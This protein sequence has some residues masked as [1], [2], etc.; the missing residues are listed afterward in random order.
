MSDTTIDN[1]QFFID[2]GKFVDIILDDPKLFQ[3]TYH[4]LEL[5]QGV[6]YDN[7]AIAKAINAEAIKKI[8]EEL[9][10]SKP[11]ADASDGANIGACIC[12]IFC[13]LLLFVPGG[14]LV[15]ISGIAAT[16]GGVGATVASL[17]LAATEFGMDVDVQIKLKE[18]EKNET[19]MLA[20]NLAYECASSIGVLADIDELYQKQSPLLSSNQCFMAVA[21]E[22]DEAKGQVEAFKKG[23]KV[24]QNISRDKASIDFFKRFTKDDLLKMTTKDGLL[25]D[26]VAIAE[27]VKAS[28]KVPL[29]IQKVVSGVGK[30][31]GVMKG[32]YNRRPGRIVDIA[33]DAEFGVEDM[34]LINVTQNMSRTGVT[35]A[36][37]VIGGASKFSKCFAALGGILDVVGGI[38]S[39]IAIC[40]RKENA[41]EMQKKLQEA[42]DN[43]SDSMDE[44]KIFQETFFPR[45]GDALRVIIDSYRL[46]TL[47][48]NQKAFNSADSSLSMG[49]VIDNRSKYTFDVYAVVPFYGS[50]YYVPGGSLVGSK[51]MSEEISDRFKKEG[52]GDVLAFMKKKD[53]H[54][55]RCIGGASHW[56]GVTG[57][58]FSGMFVL[59]ARGE[60][61]I[62]IPIWFYYSTSKPWEVMGAYADIP[63]FYGSDGNKIYQHMKN[64]AHA[65]NKVHSWGGNGVH[66]IENALLRIS[67]SDPSKR[68]DVTIED[69][70]K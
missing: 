10:K 28:L 9:A 16:V 27:L 23:L 8:K 37:K 64:E 39:I 2:F 41:E 70:I 45:P 43:F 7:V 13:S 40:K 60:R 67:F 18:I 56:W 61:E 26:P 25:A 57:F 50:W 31:F 35:E 15:A 46:D 24:Y 49:L 53:Y 68:I 44:I 19:T 62:Q 52:S 12:G 30:V 36:G 51:Q 54:M 32:C 4:L 29:T 3:R 59:R 11:T 17:G 58:C 1:A 22:F 47:K 55:N 66:T 69:T 20:H 42:L 21:I 38:L 33:G 6:D 63:G 34:E 65:T 14:Q 5:V 48:A